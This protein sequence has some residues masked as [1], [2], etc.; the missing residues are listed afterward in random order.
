MTTRTS[1]FRVKDIDTSEAGI[2]Y[3]MPSYE[4]KATKVASVVSMINKNGK[5]HETLDNNMSKKPSSGPKY[6]DLP[7]PGI[8]FQLIYVYIASNNQ[9]FFIFQKV[10]S[11]RVLK[12]FEPFMRNETVLMYHRR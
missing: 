3:E 9:L 7:P 6:H 1:S 8:I 11:S 5:I 12:R 10:V 2:V 4:A